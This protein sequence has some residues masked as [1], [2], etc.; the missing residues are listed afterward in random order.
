[1]YIYIYI[2]IH[3]P[4]AQSVPYAYL[5][6]WSNRICHAPY[7]W[8]HIGS[9]AHDIVIWMQISQPPCLLCTQE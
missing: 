8:F 2:Y 5:R 9:M 1:M 7:D 6:K 3:V 4:K